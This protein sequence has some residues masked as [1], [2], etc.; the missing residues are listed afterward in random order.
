[1][2][3][4][5]GFAP[6]NEL[7]N[8]TV[9]YP[10]QRN[11]RFLFDDNVL[12]AEQLFKL[13]DKAFVYEAAGADALFFLFAVD[14]HLLGAGEHREYQFYPVKYRVGLTRELDPELLL[15]RR[16]RGLAGRADV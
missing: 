15:R 11:V 16:R 4:A 1:M 5:G 2:Q 7:V 12:L 3:R 14:N 9:S 8:N 6:K 10:A 13:F